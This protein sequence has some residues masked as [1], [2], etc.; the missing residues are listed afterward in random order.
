MVPIHVHTLLSS[1]ACEEDRDAPWKITVVFKNV[2]RYSP[3][4]KL[5]YQMWFHCM[6]KCIHPLVPAMH[7]IRKMPFCPF[8]ST[9]PTRIHL[10]SAGK[11]CNILSLL[12][13]RAFQLY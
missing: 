9:R 11:A 8:L 1:L 3:Q 7:L 5:L 10:L 13:L 6:S 12:Y 2:T 4:F